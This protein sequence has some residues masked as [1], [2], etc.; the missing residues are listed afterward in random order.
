M[1]FIRQ[2]SE[3]STS[4]VV[5]T[6]ASD[7][8]NLYAPTRPLSASRP[9]SASRI[10]SFT[11]PPPS[12]HPL[13]TSILSDHQHPDDDA[14]QPYYSSQLS[15]DYPSGS[16]IRGGSA[17]RPPNTKESPRRPP[18]ATAGSGSRP[19]SARRGFSVDVDVLDGV[20]VVEEEPA[21]ELPDDRPSDAA[22]ADEWPS[23]LADGY[24]AYFLRTLHDIFLTSWLNLL[25]CCIPIA[26]IVFYVRAPPAVI[27]VFSLL[28]LCP[29]A[30]R[31]AFVTD[32]MAKYTNDTFGGLMS[33]SMGNVTELIVAIVAIAEGGSLLIVTQLS[34]V[35]SIVSN[36]LLVLGCA[37]LAGGYKHPHQ[38]Y[39][40]PAVNA[41]VGL[42]L[43]STMCLV[44]PT[45]MTVCRTYNWYGINGYP[46]YYNVNEPNM[47]DSRTLRF[48]L[49]ISVMMLI[50]YG[51]LIYYQ[52]FTHRSQ[53]ETQ[54]DEDEEE[55]APVLGL[56]GAVGWALL[57]TALIAILSELIV[58]SIEDAADSLGIPIMFVSTIILPVVGNAAEHTSAI[59]FAYRNKM[60]I[61]MGIAVGSAT[62][63]SLFVIPLCVI[64]AKCAAKELTLDFGTFHVAVLFMSIL[65]TVVSI[66]TGT[67]DW[68]KG[69]LLVFAYMVLAAAYWVID[70]PA[71][72]NEA[73]EPNLTD[74]ADYTI[75][76]PMTNSSTGV[77]M[78]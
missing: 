6:A 78:R 58:G 39:S 38:R 29:L 66:Q 17:S 46:S 21:A 49:A 31:I 37:F 48:S 11:R 32:E 57:I 7:G 43:L 22:M 76:A 15:S 45:L 20:S 56:W 18:S 54:E 16:I 47:P 24:K 71:A 74:P 72:L 53:F 23:V 25:L 44:L 61:S 33:A 60:D 40:K 35:G 67:S 1:S 41:N 13:S 63:I 42:L 55:T 62:Q 26:V 68:M 8:A 4:L 34:L 30:E 10:P 77:A 14:K 36:L 59:I 50:L 5:N 64:I 65:I 73:G 28:S 69:A 9:S 52:L 70:T 2:R 3:G 75:R 51:F 27:F 19:G 12:P